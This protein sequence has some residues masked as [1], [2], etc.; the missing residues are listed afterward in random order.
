MFKVNIIETFEPFSGN[1]SASEIVQALTKEAD[2]SGRVFAITGTTLASLGFETAKALFVRN[3]D[4]IL[5]NR[6]AGKMKDTVAEIT[7]S[8][9][10]GATGHLH[11]VVCDLSSQTSV[12]DAALQ[13]KQILNDRNLPLDTLI[14]SAGRYFKEKQVSEDGF[15][16]TMAIDHYGHFALTIQLLDVMK[17]NGRVVVLSSLNHTKVENFPLEDL[18]FEKEDYDWQKAH[19]RAKLANL[20]FSHQLNAML[21]K[22]GSAIVSY[23]VHPGAAKTNFAMDEGFVLRNILKV[24]YRIYGTTTDV[25]AGTM[26]FAALDPRLEGRRKLYLAQCGISDETNPLL[27]DDD[28]LAAFFEHS[29]EA[30]GLT[31]PSF[32]QGAV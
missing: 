29:L 1:T 28:L 7:K 2:L 32:E 23:G 20:M 9:P 31:F 22:A 4:V 21:E 30:T 13:V 16:M 11:E 17:V 3:A 19:N 6:S 15:E 14:C 26:I 24:I 25:A 27:D 12:R 8:Q 5:L 10:E 18:K